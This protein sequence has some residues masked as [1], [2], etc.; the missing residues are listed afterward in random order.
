MGNRACSSPS[1]QTKRVGR[2]LSRGLDLSIWAK[3]VREG[4]ARN[5]IHV[6]IGSKMT[7]RETGEYDLEGLSSGSSTAIETV[8]AKLVLDT[9]EDAL[10]ISNTALLRAEIR[11]LFQY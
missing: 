3:L 10:S 11:R 6:H 2:K 4:K 1:T 5:P 8:D 9:I 7:T